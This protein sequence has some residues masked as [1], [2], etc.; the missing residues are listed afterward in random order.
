MEQECA[1]G[2]GRIPRRG[3]GR[4]A[5]QEGEF[6]RFFQHLFPL[7][8]SQDPGKSRSSAE[9]S[10]LHFL[11]CGSFHPQA[12]R[13][14]SSRLQ[15]RRDTPGWKC[16]NQKSPSGGGGGTLARPGSSSTSAATK[17]TPWPP[18]PA[19][20]PRKRGHKI[21]APRHSLPKPRVRSRVCSSEGPPR[22]T[23]RAPEPEQEQSLPQTLQQQ[24]G[25]GSQPR[26][27]RERHQHC[28]H[29]P[30][31]PAALTPLPYGC[32][33]QSQD[34]LGEGTLKP[35]PCH[36]C[37][38]QGHL[39]GPGPAAG[40]QQHTEGGGPACPGLPL[41]QAL[42]KLFTSCQKIPIFGARALWDSAPSFPCASAVRAAP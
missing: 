37:H 24:Q 20:G 31:R 14:P 11:I 10:R 33:C 18:Q 12:P 4:K 42:G 29:T 34:G 25:E 6:K 3:K 1:R 35:T 5:S 15:H 17:I 19:P 7:P 28:R 41:P 8:L 30:A 23:P 9:L 13:A 16:S 26:H 39:P 32:F 38:V 21:A 36:P 2:A 40:R 22:S 27:S